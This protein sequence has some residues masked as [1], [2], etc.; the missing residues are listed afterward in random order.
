MRSS[1]WSVNKGRT[2]FQ[3]I[4]AGLFDL[5]T[6]YI[7]LFGI[8]CFKMKLLIFMKL[9]KKLIT[10]RKAVWLKKQTVKKQK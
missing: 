6:I 8:K 3:V 2:P 4:Q 9:D 7:F 1:A 5:K 10:G